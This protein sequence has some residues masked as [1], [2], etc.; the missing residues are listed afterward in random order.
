M[1]TLRA[2]CA[3]PRILRVLAD[4]REFVLA[5][6]EFQPE[7][8]QFALHLAV[9]VHGGEG[10]ALRFT[11]LLVDFGKRLLRQAQLG[12]DG[13]DRGLLLAHFMREPHH[14]CV[15]GPQFT[16][17][18]QRPDLIGAA[19]CY[20]AALVAGA[21]GSDEGVLRIF[22]SQFFRRSRAFVQYPGRQPWQDWLRC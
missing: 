3:L 7:T 5:D 15:Q 22:A 11:L 1:L 17:H 16:L 14:L 8:T 2:L 9:A 4:A 12:S 10:F 6:S 20:H 19:T 21:I 13:F 18:A